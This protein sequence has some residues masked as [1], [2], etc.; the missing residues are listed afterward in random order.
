VTYLDE[1]IAAENS[2]DRIDDKRTVDHQR[3]AVAMLRRLRTNT[4]ALERPK[5]TS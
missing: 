4:Q 1:M 5:E 2:L 3:G